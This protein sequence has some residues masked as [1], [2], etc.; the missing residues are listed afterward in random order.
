MQ[1]ETAISREL[2]GKIVDEVFDGAIEDSSVIEEIYAVIKREE[3]ALSNVPEPKPLDLNITKDWLEKRAALEADHEIGAGSRKLT[4]C[5]DPTPDELA[6]LFKIAHRIPDG[7]QFVPVEP[8]ALSAAEPVAW[9]YRHDNVVGWSYS[10]TK[11]PRSDL[12]QEALYAVLSAQ[13]Q[14]VA[15][16]PAIKAISAERARQIEKE[17]WSPE[18]DDNHSRGELARAAAYYA[19]QAAQRSDE[20]PYE[21]RPGRGRWRR[22]HLAIVRFWPWHWGWWKPVDRQRDLEKAGALIAAELDRVIRA[23]APAKQEGGQ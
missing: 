7:W 9:R 19:L 17:G 14:D 20:T 18:H 3:A 10:D 13:V 15:D 6:E 23:A 5:I 16:S 2:M 22:T 11:H 8:A 4:A 1:S 12:E 21:D